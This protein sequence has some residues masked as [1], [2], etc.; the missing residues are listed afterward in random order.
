MI[1]NVAYFVYN[2]D[3]RLV[4]GVYNDYKNALQLKE[5][6]KGMYN[7]DIIRHE[8]KTDFKKEELNDTNR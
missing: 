5:D 1:K 4:E 2:K 7:T 3:I 8:Y 6:L